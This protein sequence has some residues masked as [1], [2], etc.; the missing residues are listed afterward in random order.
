MKMFSQKE[1]KK[2]ILNK[3]KPEAAVDVFPSFSSERY[4]APAPILYSNSTNDTISPLMT[5]SN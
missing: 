4:G 2:K 5:E 3:R 1:K